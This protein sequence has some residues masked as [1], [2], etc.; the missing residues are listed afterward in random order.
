MMEGRFCKRHFSS[1]FHIQDLSPDALANELKS[2]VLSPQVV[3]RQERKM[4]IRGAG[5]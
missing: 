2:A 4:W 5:D 1:L 3:L